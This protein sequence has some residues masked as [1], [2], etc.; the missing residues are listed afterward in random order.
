MTTESLEKK[1]KDQAMS[2]LPERQIDDIMAM[3]WEIESID[4][5]GDIARATVSA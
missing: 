2:A 5:V 4:D 1:F 3:C